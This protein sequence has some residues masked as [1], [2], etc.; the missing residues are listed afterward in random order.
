MSRPLPL[1]ETL[2]RPQTRAGSHGALPRSARE[3]VPGKPGPRRRGSIPTGE[4]ARRARVPSARLWPC[5]C[6]TVARGLPRRDGGRRT[7]TSGGTKPLKPRSAAAVGSHD[8]TSRSTNGMRGSGLETGLDLRSDE[9][10]EGGIPRALPGRNKPG[11]GRRAETVKRVR[12]PGGGTC[13]VLTTRD[14]R[15]S[16]P[17][18]AEGTQSPGG[19]PLPARPGWSRAPQGVAIPRSRCAVAADLQSRPA[20]E[21]KPKGGRIASSPKRSEAGRE[22][23]EAVRN[24]TGGA[25]NS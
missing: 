1:D 10:P 2:E 15:I 16:D 20:G 25:S 22:N 18:S 7:R 9:S 14:Q 19:S 5:G 13:R 6:P 4:N 24:G 21:R 11:R 3:E 8:P 17:A 23:P 12:N